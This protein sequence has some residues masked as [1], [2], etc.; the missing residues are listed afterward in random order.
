MS[1][2]K[3]DSEQIFAL[4]QT[5]KKEDAE[6]LVKAFQSVS[7]DFISNPKDALNFVKEMKIYLESVKPKE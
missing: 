6:K 2:F 3:S 1:V 7:L 5:M 4:L